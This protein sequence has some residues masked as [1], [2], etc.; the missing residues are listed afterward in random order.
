MLSCHKQIGR[1][2]PSVFIVLHPTVT[3]EKSDAL[4]HPEV[5]FFF[6]FLPFFNSLCLYNTHIWGLYEQS[7]SGVSNRWFFKQFHLLKWKTRCTV[8]VCDNSWGKKQSFWRVYHQHHQQIWDEKA[9][10]IIVTFQRP[11][12]SK[13]S[14]RKMAVVPDDMTWNSSLCLAHIYYQSLASVWVWNGGL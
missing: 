12:L 3:G 10:H 14:E 7:K 2:S 13:R 11:F 5:N 8:P 9:T 1:D 4:I 6:V